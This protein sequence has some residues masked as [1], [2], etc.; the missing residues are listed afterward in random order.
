MLH[1]KQNLKPGQKLSEHTQYPLPA[2]RLQPLGE[3]VLT[4]PAQSG[5]LYHFLL[6]ASALSL[7]E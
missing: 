5:K 2:R 1:K 6:D 4:A 7:K 3:T